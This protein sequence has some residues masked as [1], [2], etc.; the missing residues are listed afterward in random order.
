VYIALEDRRV[1]ALRG[2]KLVLTGQLLDSAQRGVPGLRVEI[3]ILKPAQRQRML[4]AVQ[5]SD[6]DGYFRA[7]FGIPPD[8]SVGDYRLIARSQGDATHL[9]AT[10][11]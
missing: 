8:L 3:W 7:D 10:T 1:T 6:Q 2:G 9:P 4:L 5:V 11:E